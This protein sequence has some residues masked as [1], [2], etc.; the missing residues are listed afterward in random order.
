MNLLCVAQ[1]L[2]VYLAW[3]SYSSHVH[4]GSGSRDRKWAWHPKN[5]APWISNP[6]T[7]ST[8]LAVLSGSRQAV[9]QHSITT[10]WQISLSCDGWRVR[11]QRFRTP[12]FSAR[13]RSLAVI[14]LN[15]SGIVTAYWLTVHRYQIDGILLVSLRVW[16]LMGASH[17]SDEDHL[18]N[19]STFV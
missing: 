3:P 14:A 5:S 16:L 2:F 8:V 4:S 15:T 1:C 9:G 11:L 6:G 7:A 13:L 17:I 18:E 12:D 10:L 19:R